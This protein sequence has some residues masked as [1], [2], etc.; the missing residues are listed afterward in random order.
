MRWQPPR[1]NEQHRSREGDETHA[2]YADLVMH[3]NAEGMIRMG[4]STSEVI[5]I[6]KA[7]KHRDAPQGLDSKSVV[8]ATSSSEQ[9][10]P[11]RK[12]RS[13]Q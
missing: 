9:T 8:R 13:S 6:E 4:T 1:R 10:E 3:P 11:T 12:A 5:S 7:T 2:E